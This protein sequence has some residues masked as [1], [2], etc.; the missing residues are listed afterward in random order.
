M[1]IT[2]GSTPSVTCNTLAEEVV[3]NTLGI[4]LQ[5][6]IWG[7]SVGKNTG[8]ENTLSHLISFNVGW[9]KHAAKDVL[10]KRKTGIVLTIVAVF[11]PYKLVE[12]GDI[13]VFAS[14]GEMS[15]STLKLQQFPCSQVV[16]SRTAFGTVTPKHERTGKLF[17][18]FTNGFLEQANIN[19]GTICPRSSL[20]DD[21]ERGTDR[22]EKFADWLVYLFSGSI[23]N[24]VIGRT[25]VFSK[26]FKAIGT[27][28]FE[29][30]GMTCTKPLSVT[31][32]CMKV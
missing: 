22:M 9:A 13:T 26:H 10:L 12:V 23:T 31:N 1:C 30:I 2:I 19:F 5:G 4:I 6:R 14:D 15:I 18:I 17:H 29:F 7:I 20:F 11:I 8:F 27:S 28:L 3:R 21:M 32:N 16:D 24:H 25:D